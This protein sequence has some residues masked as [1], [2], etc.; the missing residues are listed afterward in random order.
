MAS[1]VSECSIRTDVPGNLAAALLNRVRRWWG[2]GW[3]INLVFFAQF[4]AGIPENPRE[5]CSLLLSQPVQLKA[6][7]DDSW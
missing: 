4:P 6:I 1:V 5:D 7:V 3:R 2:W